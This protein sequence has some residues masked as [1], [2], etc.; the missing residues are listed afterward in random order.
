[1]P[2]FQRI[3]DIIS[4]NLNELIDR[5]EDPPAMLR[6]AVR[7]MESSVD[8]T[9]QA[10]AQAI[11]H[12]RLL[13][14]ELAQ[15]RRRVDR[16]H[17][18]AAAALRQDDEPAARHA[19]AERARLQV[20]ISA[21]DDQLTAAGNESGVLRRQAQALRLRLSEARHMQTA[22]PRPQPGRRCKGAIDPRHD[23]GGLECRQFRAI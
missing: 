13:E 8:E 11:A 22:V 2:I 4:A 7:E 3:T 1:M 6:Q 20:L 14:R 21:L 5:F 19:L 9:M 12:E 16:L 15:R 10:A 18:L 23:S 17:E